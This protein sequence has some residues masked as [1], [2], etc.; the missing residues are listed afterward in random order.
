NSIAESYIN[1]SYAIRYQ[2]ANGLSTFMTKQIE[3]LQAKMERS[4]AALALFQKELNVI[5]PDEKTNILSARLLQLNTEYNAAQAERFRK[6]VAA[7]STLSGSVEALEVSGQ[8][9]QIRK[10]ADRIAEEDQKFAAIK[11]HYAS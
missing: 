9:E 10:L 8:G 1:H 11:T 6:E 7:K 5:S 4:S 2:A 3:E